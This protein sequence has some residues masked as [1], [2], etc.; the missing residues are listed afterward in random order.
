MV[1]VR[2]PR[3]IADPLKGAAPVLALVVVGA[4]VGAVRGGFTDLFVYQYGGRA[5]L[6]GVPVYGAAT[7]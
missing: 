4:V 5:V 6:D 7:R 2:A 3:R 1:L